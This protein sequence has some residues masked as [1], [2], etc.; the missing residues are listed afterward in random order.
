M[1]LKIMEIK[2]T[3]VTFEQAKFFLKKGLRCK[4]SMYYINR[5][6]FDVENPKKRMTKDGLICDIPAPEQWQ[7][8]EWLRV[9]HDIW[10]SVRLNNTKNSWMYFLQETITK[11]LTQ[12]IK[13]GFNTPQEAY[14]AAFDYI[15]NT[16][17]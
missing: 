17:I 3:Y 6:Q 2:P 8:V 7:V 10:V 1:K 11:Q 16:L 5:D 12:N 9:N 13:D 4:V 15:L 14:S